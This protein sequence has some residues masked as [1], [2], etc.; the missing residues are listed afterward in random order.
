MQGSNMRHRVD[1]ER[2]VAE[3]AQRLREALQAGG[4]TVVNEFDLQQALL[5]ACHETP[6][7][8]R[9]FDVCNAAQAVAMMHRDMD[10]VIGVTHRLA[11]YDHVG[12]T[13]IAMLRPTHVLGA[14]TPSP[15]RMDIAE[16]TEQKIA[17]IMDRAR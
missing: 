8:A 7:A 5:A 10:L 16:E 9:L 17:Q 2:S 11:V 14:M 3:A 15:A 12:Q 1:T 6:N 4:F 13:R